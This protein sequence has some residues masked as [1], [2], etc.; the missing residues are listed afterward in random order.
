[1]VCVTEK[2]KSVR[3]VRASANV[4]EMEKEKMN[5]SVQEKEKERGEKE[6]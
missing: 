1:M 5:N 3:E 4:R 2:R 6:R